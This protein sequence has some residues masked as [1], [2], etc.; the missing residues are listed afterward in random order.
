MV[1][2]NINLKVDNQAAKNAIQDVTKDIDDLEKRIERIS[3]ARVNNN[4]TLSNTQVAT[5]QGG[6]SD[7]YSDKTK[8]QQMLASVQKNGDTLV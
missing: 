4:N 1:E 5:A 6:L 3:N 2:E 8:L 7:L